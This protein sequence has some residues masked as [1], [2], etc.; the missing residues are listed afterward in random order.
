M[1]HEQITARGAGFVRAWVFG[2][3]AVYLLGQ[4]PRGFARVPDIEF[5]PPGILAIL[6]DAFYDAL[7]TST[8]LGMLKWITLA[9]VI[10]CAFGV[11]PW[12]AIAIPTVILLTLHQGVPR[13]MF[14]Y[15]NHKELGALYATY[16]LAVFPATG[17]SLFA[18]RQ[19][20]PEADRDRTTT[21]MM[22]LLLTAA[23]LIPYCLVGL[24]RLAHNDMTLWSTETFAHFMT[25][26]SYGTSWFENS[27]FSEAALT[28]PWL[29]QLLTI[30]L[31]IGT[32][33]EVLAPLCIIHRRF[34]YVWA[35]SMA[36]LH[37]LTWLTMD[38]LFW[39]NLALFPVLLIDGEY[40]LKKYDAVR[41]RFGET[42]QTEVP[43]TA[44]A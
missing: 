7:L 27:E 16:V 21:R 8:G 15:V 22:M 43:A 12:R 18:P 17:F 6:P 32:V 10:A 23:L 13:G 37:I 14:G 33:I 44:A 11:R 9:A 42:T 28:R 31:P 5:D 36:G 4:D 29:I 41:S 38:I 39:E 40:L 24:Y 30:S 2:L 25:Q 34:R 3:W 20:K 1:I 35:L 19:P 26:T